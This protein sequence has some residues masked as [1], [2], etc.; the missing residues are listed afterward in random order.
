MGP[1][2][3]LELVSEERQG[4]GDLNA[5][6]RRAPD[7]GAVLSLSIRE[8]NKRIREWNSL[9]HS[10]TNTNSLKDFALKMENTNP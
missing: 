7:D 2:I 4:G 3:A 5:P 9:D 6:R 1:R 10:V 8:W